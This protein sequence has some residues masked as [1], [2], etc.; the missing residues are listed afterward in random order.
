MRPEEKK[1]TWKKTKKKNAKVVRKIKN[2]QR[3]NGMK[4]VRKYNTN[5][6]ARQ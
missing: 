5:K 2:T 6:G 1:E 4:Q 3:H